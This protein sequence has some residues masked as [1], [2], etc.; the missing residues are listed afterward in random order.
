MSGLSYKESGK[1]VAI[2]DPIFAEMTLVGNI[3]TDNKIAVY[4]HQD[5]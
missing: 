4:Y 5:P 1:P 2:G 3:F